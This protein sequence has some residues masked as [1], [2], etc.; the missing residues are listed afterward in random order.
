MNKSLC[1]RKLTYFFFFQFNVNYNYNFRDILGKIFLFRIRH[2]F[3]NEKRKFIEK[4][5]WQSTVL[6]GLLSK[7]NNAN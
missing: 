1:G 2:G 7:T 4:K 3:K 6:N 5:L